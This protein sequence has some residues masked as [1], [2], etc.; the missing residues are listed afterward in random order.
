MGKKSATV[1]TGLLLCMNWYFKRSCFLLTVL[2]WRSCFNSLV[3]VLHFTGSFEWQILKIHC[4][5][6]VFENFLNRNKNVTMS[7]KCRI[8]FVS[9]SPSW[10]IYRY[11]C[12]EG[13]S[14]LVLKAG[15]ARHNSGTLVRKIDCR[16]LISVS[17]QRTQSLRK[18]G[19]RT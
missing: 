12:W 6:H 4:Q 2:S 18:I 13:F 1:C 10:G 5:S 9:K 17:S 8:L 19:P 14:L 7:Q 15:L 3:D 11:N 16:L